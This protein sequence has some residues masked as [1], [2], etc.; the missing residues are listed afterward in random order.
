[1]SNIRILLVEDEVVIADN[2]KFILEDLG[3]EVCRPVDKI[4]QAIE[5]LNTEKPDLAILDINLKGKHDGIEIARYINTHHVIPFIFLTSNADKNTVDMA[6][7][8]NPAAYLVKP[9]SEE[10][11]YATIEVAITNFT[12]ANNQQHESNVLNS[13]FFVKQNHTFIKLRHEEIDYVK[14]EDKYLTIF[15]TPDRK[16]LVRMSLEQMLQQLPNTQF[17]Q[18][19]RSYIVNLS[20]LDAVNTVSVYIKHTEIPISRIHYQSLIGKMRTLS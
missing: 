6:K 2:L 13:C 5:A 20:K 16:Y 8:T 17:M 15:C 1:M 18:V 10:D 4:E 14:S 19:H 11:I 9:F 7:S 3:Y 12:K